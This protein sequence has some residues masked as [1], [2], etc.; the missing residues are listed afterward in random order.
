[1]RTLSDLIDAKQ[2]QD[3][4]NEEVEEAKFN[5]R[6]QKIEREITKQFEKAKYTTGKRLTM[7]KQHESM[8][9]FSFDTGDEDYRTVYIHSNN[10]W[11]TL[12]VDSE[13]SINLMNA[14]RYTRE[15]IKVLGT[16]FYLKNLNRMLINWC[17][18]VTEKIIERKNE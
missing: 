15:E 7:R 8:Y 11:K 9:Y 2:K 5:S 3:K 14:Y 12:N 18:I 10:S 6:V 17:R 13:F 16:A 4:H 1:M